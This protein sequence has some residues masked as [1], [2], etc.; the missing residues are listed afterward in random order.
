MTDTQPIERMTSAAA[1]CRGAVEAGRSVFVYVLFGTF[2]GYGALAHDL[3]F[4]ISWSLTS[5]ALIWAGP[6]QVIVVSALGAGST[7]VQAAVAVALSGIR[8]MPM[9]VA[10]L[11]MVKTPK[12]RSWQLLASA[13]FIAVS[14]WVESFR[15]IPQIPRER[16]LAFCNGLGAGLMVPALVA[17]AIGYALAA[18]LPTVLGAAVLFITPIAFLASTARNSRLLVDKLALVFGLVLAPVFAYAQVELDMLLAGVTAGTL[19]YGCHRFR[20]AMR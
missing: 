8:L 7:L 17:T 9:V 6:A 5:T 18:R 14:M 11:P 19:A 13:H 16:R 15:L 10:L 2:I 3:G 4:T 1:F 20:E 12:T